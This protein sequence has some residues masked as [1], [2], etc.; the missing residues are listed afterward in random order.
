MT[1]DFASVLEKS[2]AFLNYGPIGLAALFL[3]L[4]I[5]AAVIPNLNAHRTNLLKWVLVAGSFCFV[6]ALIPQ[7][8]VLFGKT[9]SGAPAQIAA[10]RSVINTVDISIPSL[11]GANSWVNGLICSGGP[12]G[13]AADGHQGPSSALVKVIGDLSGLKASAQS[14]LPAK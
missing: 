5:G 11:Q 8:I 14:A 3:V 12:H 13:L 10:L 6:F 2:V 1:F 9:N 4:I 7:Y